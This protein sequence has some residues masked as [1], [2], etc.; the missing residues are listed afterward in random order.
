MFL[1]DNY[2]YYLPIALQGFCAWHSFNRGTQQKW[3]WM[4]VFLPVI[5]SFIYIYQEIL[6]HRNISAPKINVGAVLNPGGKLK[7]LEQELR[8]TDTFNN[9]IKLA[10]AYL[11]AGYIDNALELYKA[12]LTGAFAENEHVLQQLIAAYYQL[13]QYEEILP[14]ARKL[15]QTP[16]F[17]RSRAHILYALALEQTGNPEQAEKEF[18]AMKGRYSYFEQRY[19]YGL[20]LIRQ[21]REEDAAEIFTAMLDE[22]PHLG[23]VERR[24][25][26]E[27]FAR[28]KDEMKKLK[29]VS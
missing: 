24:A 15:Y 17:I 12:S 1:G 7:K 13:E 22:Q 25:S 23:A 26:K 9:R 8:F 19:Q 6:S 3:I 14:I 20:F 5:G 28:A 11:A 29:F 2:L 10:D 18:K 16:Q 27:W 4:I 21:N